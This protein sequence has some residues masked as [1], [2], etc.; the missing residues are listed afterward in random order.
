MPIPITATQ[1]S[2][3]LHDA[4]EWYPGTINTIEEIDGEYGPGLKWILELDDDEPYDDGTQPQTWA[5]SSQTY[6]TRSKLYKWLS[7][8]NLNIDV[9]DSFDIET[10]VGRRVDVMFERTEGFDRDGRPT[11]KEKVVNIRA[12]KVAAAP[13]DDQSP[14]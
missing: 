9:G 10:I 3:F 4:G 14:F 12:S 5:F 2:S 8:F 1:A 6:S 7:G 11:E 13:T